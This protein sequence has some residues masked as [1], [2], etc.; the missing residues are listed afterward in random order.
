MNKLK[1]KNPNYK[2]YLISILVIFIDQLTKILVMINMNLGTEIK[3][4]PNFFSLIYLVNNGAALSTFQNQRALI[5]IVSLFCMALIVSLMQREK[6]MTKLKTISF[7][8][9]IGG[10]LSNLIDRVFYKHVVDFISFTIFNYK[11]PIFNIADIGITV[12]VLIYIIINI[13]EEIIEKRK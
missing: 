11:C 7:G 3:I 4:I 6:N 5:I 8:I 1:E 12:G 2:V 10:M 9:L 13:Y